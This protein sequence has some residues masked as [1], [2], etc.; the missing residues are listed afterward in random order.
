MAETRGGG[1][2]ITR[3]VEGK[4]GRSQE[5][6]EEKGRRP[7]RPFRSGDRRTEGGEVG[8]EAVVA[9]GLESLW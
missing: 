4:G 9:G 5:E 2:R 7:R 6:L 8:W 1:R 3:S